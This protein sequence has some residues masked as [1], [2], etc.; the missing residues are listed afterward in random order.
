MFRPDKI[1]QFDAPSI[2]LE[3]SETVRGQVVSELDSDFG[4]ALVVLDRWVLGNDLFGIDR[5]WIDFA[6]LRPI[7]FEVLSKTGD[8]MRGQV[9]GEK[10]M[11][12]RLQKRHF[13]MSVLA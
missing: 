2:R 1:S 4:S 9:V 13:R 5:Q 12:V 6:N 10:S 7:T 11:R 8:S 3:R